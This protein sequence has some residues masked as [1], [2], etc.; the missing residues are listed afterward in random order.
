MYFDEHDVVG[1]SCG[2]QFDVDMML[3]EQ[4]PTPPAACSIALPQ[5]RFFTASSSS[6]TSCSASANRAGKDPSWCSSAHDSAHLYKSPRRRRRVS[7]T[8]HT[9]TAAAAAVTDS[10]TATLMEPRALAALSIVVPSSQQQSQSQHESES[11]LLNAT[12]MQQLRLQTPRKDARGDSSC[13]LLRHSIDSIES[14]SPRAA[15]KRAKRSRSSA[16]SSP[17]SSSSSSS[18]CASAV[19]LARK[20]ALKKKQATAHVQRDEADA[21]D[22][23]EERDDDE[24]EVDEEEL[25]PPVSSFV[26]YVRTGACVMDECSLFISRTCVCVSV[27]AGRVGARP[28]R[29]RAE[30]GLL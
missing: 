11:G 7:P 24:H 10:P 9:T 28:P 13:A 8:H 15:L 20:R 30:S 25:P 26:E 23:E 1:E 14:E 29:A 18:S 3:A 17:A 12:A 27:R 4:P 21:S 5:P 2:T 22:R 19:A 16:S 6:S